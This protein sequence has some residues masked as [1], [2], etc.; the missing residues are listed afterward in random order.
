[1]RGGQ[2]RCWRW[3]IRRGWNIHLNLR[4]RLL[5]NILAHCPH[6]RDN[7]SNDRP[8]QEKIQSEDGSRVLFLVRHRDERWDEVQA[9][10]N[11]QYYYFHEASP[12]VDRLLAFLVTANVSLLVANFSAVTIGEPRDANDDAEKHKNDKP[13]KRTKFAHVFYLTPTYLT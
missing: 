13:V 6:E 8:A 9:D 3:D 5:L 1:L 7:P 11:H 12:P 10:A 4:R 2:G